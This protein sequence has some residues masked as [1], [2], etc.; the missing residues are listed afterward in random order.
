M[1]LSVV[2]SAAFTE[3]ISYCLCR[4]EEAEIVEIDEILPAS[5]IYWKNLSNGNT[6]NNK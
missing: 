5:C 2:I 6:P 4:E 1:S 3:D